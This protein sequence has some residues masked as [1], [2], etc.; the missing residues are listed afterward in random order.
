MITIVS[1]EHTSGMSTKAA[2]RRA[3]RQ[4]PAEILAT[5]CLTA[6][7]ETCG[8]STDRAFAPFYFCKAVYSANSAT[9]LTLKIESWQKKVADALEE[10]FHI[11]AI[12]QLGWWSD[13]SGGDP[14]QPA[15]S[16]ALLQ[17][18]AAVGIHT[19]LDIAGGIP[20][21]SQAGV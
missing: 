15:F 2:L 18:C 20:F 9:T 14:A 8:T 17:A 4:L 5:G 12:H 1:R 11:G 3:I 10:L 19:A 7:I 21:A 13:L 6:L 16:A